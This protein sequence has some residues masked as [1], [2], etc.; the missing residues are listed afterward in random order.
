MCDIIG[1][2]DNLTRILKMVEHD[3]EFLYDMNDKEWYEAN[4]LEIGSR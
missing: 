1:E 4:S 2:F 3:V